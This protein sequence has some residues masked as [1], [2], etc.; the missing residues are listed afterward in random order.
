MFRASL[1][2][3]QPKQSGFFNFNS[4]GPEF[5]VRVAF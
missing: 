4:K 2:S 3:A 1:I 5:F